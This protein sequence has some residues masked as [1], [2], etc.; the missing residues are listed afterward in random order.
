MNADRRLWLVLL[1]VAL[2]AEAL[3]LA[4]VIGG[5][6]AFFARDI[7]FFRL[8]YHLAFARELLAGHWPS[9]SNVLGGGMPL[10][11]HP[12]AELANPSAL[13]FAWFNPHCAYGLQVLLHMGLATVGAT[14]LARSLGVNRVLAVWAGFMFATCGPVASCWSVKMIPSASLPWVVLGA[15]LCARRGNPH[16]LTWLAIPV[17]FMLLHPDPVAVFG[18]FT[19]AAVVVFA[20]SPRHAFMRTTRRLLL[21]TTIGGLLAC[22]YLV[23][24]LLHSISSGRAEMDYIQFSRMPWLLWLDAVAPGITGVAGA[25]GPGV[26]LSLVAKGGTNSLVVSVFVGLTCVVMLTA[27]GLRRCAATR[28]NILLAVGT[29]ALAVLSRG[30]TIPGTSL[31]WSLIRSRHPDKLLLPAALLVLL[32][33][34]RLGTA[35]LRGNAARTPRVVLSV[36]CVAGLSLC[37]VSERMARWLAEMLLREEYPLFVTQ[38]ANHAQEALLSAGICLVMAAVCWWLAIARRQWSRHALVLFLVVGMWEGTRAVNQLNPMTAAERM[39]RAAE[40]LG[41]LPLRGKRIFAGDPVSHAASPNLVSPQLPDDFNY[42]ASAAFAAPASAVLQHAIY[43]VGNDVGSMES[44]P[45][46]TLLDAILP[47]LT[48]EE[49]LRVLQQFGVERVLLPVGSDVQPPQDGMDVLAWYSLGSDLRWMD[50]V[51]KH[52]LPPVGVETRWHVEDDSLTTAR[53]LGQPGS[54]PVVVAEVAAGMPGSH[55]D[56]SPRLDVMTHESHRVRVRVESASPAL[57][58]VRET[59][60]PGW[61]AVVDGVPTPVNLVNICQRAVRVPEG[62]HVVEMRY[63]TPGATVGLLLGWVGLM[64]WFGVRRKGMARSLRR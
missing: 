47:R 36:L 17:A 10:W 38:A 1:L 63:R 19:A 14:L 48:R 11:H 37:V 31:L 42:V 5:A 62:N 22:P 15:R 2:G 33:A 7:L 45:M 55:P 40:E 53:I 50:L 59:M 61:E 16:A 57:V 8:P 20:C 43:A 34:A 4:P 58:V 21:G 9:W 30:T 41:V 3:W 60:A 12:S 49:A 52:P 28:F 39:D 32:L 51:V 64:G 13:L 35:L 54:K 26:G 23:P 46:R 56:P 25:A 44:R 27:G 29:L 6:Q 24:A 18:A